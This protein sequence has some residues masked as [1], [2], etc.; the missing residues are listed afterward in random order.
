MAV[1]SRIQI[2]SDANFSI[3][4]N[5]TGQVSPRDV[6]QRIIDITDS[7]A[8]GTEVLTNDTAITAGAG[9]TG[10]GTVAFSP[11]IALSA[12][13]IASLAKADS[14]VQPART[15]AAGTGLTGGGDLSENRSI[16]LSSTSI[17]SLAL[18]DTAVQPARQVATGAGLT[19][20]GNLTADRTIAADIASEAEAQAGTSSEKL[21]T[22]QRGMDL[23]TARGKE[24]NWT[25]SG[26][27]AVA[28]TVDAWLKGRPPSVKPDFGAVADAD[29]AGGG[30]DAAAAIQA[31]LNAKQAAGGGVVF[32]PPGQYR[33]ASGITI[34]DRV[35]LLGEAG[36]TSAGAASALI[37]DLSVAICI[38]INGGAASRSAALKGIG[39]G[40]ASGAIPVGCIAVQQLDS[41]MPLI[42]DVFVWRHAI[43]LEMDSG[44][45][46]LTLQRFYTG[47]ITEVP[48]VLKNGPEVTCID[49]RFGRNGG[50]DAA[51]IEAFVRIDTSAGGGIDT[52]NFTRCQFNLSGG[53]RA[54]CLV[55]FV[56]YA[57]VNG[58][59]NFIGC[60]A[61]SFNLSTGVVL[62]SD[63]ASTV[64]RRVK[65]IGS[66][67]LVSASRNFFGL[68]AATQ[69]VD[70]IFSSSSTSFNF[71]AG[72]HASSEYTV[73]GSTLDRA[74]TCAGAGS[75]IATGNLIKSALTLS[76]A[77][78]EGVISEN[79]ILGNAGSSA[80]GGFVVG[81]N[82]YGGTELDAVVSAARHNFHIGGVVKGRLD[83]NGAWNALNGGYYRVDGQS[84]PYY[85]RADAAADKAYLG[86]RGG[87]DTTFNEVLTYT[88]TRVGI[89]EATPDY[90]LDVN[91]AIGFT[92]GSSVTPVDNGDVVFELTNNT[93]LTVK[94]KGT[95]GTVRTVALTLA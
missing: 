29:G 30:T 81:P 78:T 75:F 83:A 73:V 87:G 47:Q 48:L 80:T 20:G 63:A 31:A 82:S 58:I 8:F 62:K 36:F 91:G 13:S 71:N 54:A 43:G 3:P 21:L 57:N 2:Q 59:I 1:K 33:C 60:H 7:V 95:D 94:A 14:A 32:L 41:D 65:F 88:P 92:P 84:R 67:V 66:T 5:I 27:G 86:Y 11:T 16:A 28:T 56:G 77:I 93:T 22:P 19:G 69:L 10:G 72:G 38:T 49:C 68:N 45:V 25:P 85:L 40:R 42:E 61:E 90:T 4:D 17:A 39:V 9:L 34:P 76:G 35:I 79:I 55:D 53:G 52:V 26:T 44:A 15:I 18:A 70:F 24:A 46:G 50:L 37:F 51:N 74:L 89:M 12:S 23:I 64:I 6:R